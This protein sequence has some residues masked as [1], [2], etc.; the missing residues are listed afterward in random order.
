MVKSIR[1]PRVRQHRD[2]H[3]TLV[4][5]FH[6]YVVHLYEMRDK[7]MNLVAFKILIVCKCANILCVYLCI[8]EV[9]YSKCTHTYCSNTHSLNTAGVSQSLCSVHVTTCVFFTP[10]AQNQPA[11]QQGSCLMSDMHHGL[12]THSS[13]CIIARAQNN[14]VYLGCWAALMSNPGDTK[15]KRD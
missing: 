4:V 9:A 11:S 5:W 12:D 14:N 13:V 6:M 15:I 2:T 7:S 10:S 3:R 8:R 1:K